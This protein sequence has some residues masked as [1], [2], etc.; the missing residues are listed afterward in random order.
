MPK[1]A[2][3]AALEVL[4]DLLLSNS[5]YSH[6]IHAPLEKIDVASWVFSLPEAEYQRCAPPDH[7]AAGSTTT[8]DG[9]PMSINVEMIGTS[10]MIQHYVGEIVERHHCRLVSVSDGFT[11]AGRSKV[12]VVW[13]LSVRPIDS[14]TCEYTNSVTAHPTNLFLA[15]VEEQGMSFV[16]CEH[17]TCRAGKRLMRSQGWGR[18]QGRGMLRRLARAR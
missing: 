6:T 16:R 14:E 9:R 10:L 11:P 5:S 3:E 7:I 17:R 12:Q 18:A 4:T 2:S 13:D 15:F 8:D 1:T